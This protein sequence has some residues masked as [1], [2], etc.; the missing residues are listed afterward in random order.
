MAP[1]KEHWT[2]SQMCLSPALLLTRLSGLSFLIYEMG[3][4]IPLGLLQ[5]FSV[6]SLK[7]LG[8]INC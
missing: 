1:W 3:I 5:R 4:I 8:F 6:K 7:A 2:W